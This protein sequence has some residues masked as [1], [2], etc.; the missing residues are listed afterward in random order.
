MTDQEFKTFVNQKIIELSN[1]Y[2]KI[3]YFTLKETADIL[4]IGTRTLSKLVLDNSIPCYRIPSE[5]NKKP[6]YRFKLSDIE[7][8]M[9]KTK[10][11][12]KDNIDN[13]VKN[14]FYN[15]KSTMNNIKAN[16]IIKEIVRKQAVN[17]N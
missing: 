7:E 17:I 13:I 2:T 11:L 16:G 15:K 6:H 12:P 8:Y 14:S 3:Q 5:K 4:K 9:E 10:I 1:N